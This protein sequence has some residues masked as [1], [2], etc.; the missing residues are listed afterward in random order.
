MYSIPGLAL[1]PSLSFK[2][3]GSGGEFI[4]FDKQTD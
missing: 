1:L 4:N 3:R 2:E